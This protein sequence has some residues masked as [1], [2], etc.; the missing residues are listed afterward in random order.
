[1]SNVGT[2]DLLEHASFV[3]N[4]ARGLLFDPQAADDVAQEASLVAM[5]GEGRDR[6]WWTGVLQNLVRRERRRSERQRRNEEKAARKEAAPSTVSLVSDHS[7][8]V[9]MR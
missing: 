6:G 5:R 3:R 7:A 9:H 8:W 1:M 2:K 4:L